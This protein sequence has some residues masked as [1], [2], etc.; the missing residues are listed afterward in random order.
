LKFSEELKRYTAASID[1]IQAELLQAGCGTM[2][3]E[4]H[5]TTVSI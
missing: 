4:M 1:L 3:S 2:H 5:R